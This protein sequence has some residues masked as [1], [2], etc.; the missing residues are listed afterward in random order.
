MFYNIAQQKN[1]YL[2]KCERLSTDYLSRTG[3]KD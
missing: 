3:W 2:E 1:G